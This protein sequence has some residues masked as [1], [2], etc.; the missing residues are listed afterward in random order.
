MTYGEVTVGEICS[1]PQRPVRRRVMNDLLSRCVTRGTELVLEHVVS[2]DGCRPQRIGNSAKLHLSNE[3]PAPAKVK[4]QFV[5][6]STPPIITWP[7]TT[8]VRY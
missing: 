5:Q 6:D 1:S 4:Y 3:P 7:E 8:S 2:P